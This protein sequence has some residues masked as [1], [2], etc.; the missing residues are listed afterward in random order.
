MLIAVLLAAQIT[1]VADA[2]DE[3]HPLELDLE[4]GF[5]H[6]RSDVKISREQPGGGRSDELSHTRTLDAFQMRLAVGLWH[7]LELHALGTFALQDVQSWHGA[8]SGGTLA[9]NTI[10]VS[11]C[12]RPGSCTTVQPVLPID[13]RSERTGFFDPTVGIAWAPINEEREMLLRPELYPQGHP[14]STWALGV[15]Y[16]APLGTRID[17]P[18]RW[19]ANAG[20]G[21]PSP[22]RGSEFRKAHVITAWTA[23]S[24]RYRVLE[25]YFKVFGSAAL[26]APGAYDNCSHPEKLSDVA[27]V[28]C[29]GG[30]ARQTGYRPPYE[31]GALFGTEF[32]AGED[33][34]QDRRISFDVS[35]GLTWHGASRG[36]TQVTDALGK[37]TASDEYV[38]SMGQVGVYG[39]LARWFHMR[40]Y[41]LVGVD[42]AHFLT[43][44]DVGAD[45]DGDGTITLSGGSGTPAPDQNPNFDFRVDS[46]GRRLRAEPAL[47][48]GVG[49]T[50]SLD[51]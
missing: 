4:G 16:T 31:G 8:A 34:I 9:S 30:W 35:G 23:F 13:G 21:V 43:H 29:A 19:G 11:G 47:F 36:Y 39:R 6:I 22:G 40:V 41:G 48:W 12:A 45:K 25:P 14:S 44:E 2:A 10:D 1:N 42:S 50:L 33:L 27:P 46:V 49:G 5:V 3:K 24:K 20:T 37:L 7:D 38:T 18:S 15:D 17:N 51:F 32:V 26:A 28:N